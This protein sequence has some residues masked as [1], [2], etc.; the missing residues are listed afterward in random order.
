MNIGTSGTVTTTM[1]AD[2]QS[3]ARMRTPTTSGTITARASC[4]R[5]RAK[6]GSSASTPRVASVASSPERVPDSQPGPSR[7]AARSTWPRS[8]RTVPAAAACAADSCAHASAARAPN[9]TTSAT[10]GPA[11]AATPAPPRKAPVT[12]YAIRSACATT[13]PAVDTPIATH[14]AR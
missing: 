8:S 13:S 5:Y 2:S 7:S 14:T 1:T 12:A 10:S 4:G 6:Y 9:T 11:T 3:A